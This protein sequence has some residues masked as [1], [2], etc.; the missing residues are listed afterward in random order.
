MT[1]STSTATS[2]RSLALLCGATIAVG[3][4]A[5]LLLRSNKKNNHH[6]DNDDDD[7]K[8]DEVTTTA[9]AVASREEVEKA[10]TVAIPT[11][12]DLL[13]YGSVDDDD[14]NDVDKS[15]SSPSTVIE[16]K[17]ETPITSRSLPISTGDKVT[18]VVDLQ[19]SLIHI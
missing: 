6:D 14:D 10:P 19:L 18:E 5:Y 4:A 8:K 1:G 13:K 2:K 15:S 12:A 17:K 16:T 9:V 11:A 3:A 7:V